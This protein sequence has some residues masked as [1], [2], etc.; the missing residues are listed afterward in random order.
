MQSPVIRN[1]FILLIQAIVWGVGTCSQGDTDYKP[2]HT[3]QPFP[4]LLPA[5]SSNTVTML[6][7]WPGVMQHRVV[8][9]RE[10]VGRGAGLGVAVDGDRHG[11][12]GQ[13]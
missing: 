7:G 1:N 13:R 9:D 5:I 4:Q 2:M 12:G 6:I 8:A 10:G 3:P 11:E